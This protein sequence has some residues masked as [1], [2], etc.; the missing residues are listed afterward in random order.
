LNEYRDAK[1]KTQVRS[2]YKKL[3]F[4]NHPDKGGSRFITLKLSEAKDFLL[5]MIEK[6]EAAKKTP[7]AS[8]STSTSE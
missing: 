1:D 8:S 3:V 5:Q 2:A 7:S 6:E 4:A